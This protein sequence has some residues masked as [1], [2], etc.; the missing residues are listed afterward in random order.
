MSNTAFAAGWQKDN[1]G[2]WWQN[3]N[4]SYPSNTWQWVDGNHDGVSECY[5]FDGNG[6]MLANTTTPDGYVVNADGAWVVSG[7]VQTK[8]AE[9]QTATENQE[10]SSVDIY[11]NYVNPYGEVI[12]LTNENGAL[13]L[14]YYEDKGGEMEILASAMQKVNDTTYQSTTYEAVNIKFTN[15]TTFTFYDGIVYTKQ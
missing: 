4:G 1:T 9:A 2:W 11:G 3:D 13:I 14:R 7:T 15:N 8:A 10:Q 6:Y 5:Y 12:T